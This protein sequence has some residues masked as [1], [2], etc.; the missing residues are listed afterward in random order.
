MLGSLVGAPDEDQRAFFDELCA[1]H[2]VALQAAARHV[3]RDATIASDLVQDTL[4]RAWRNLASLQDEGHA[5]AWLVRIMRNAW[6]D[7]IRRRKVEVPLEQVEEP[8]AT[9]VDEPMDWEALTIDDVRMAIERLEEPF[10]TVAI[11]H[12][13]DGCSYQ[14]IAKRLAIPYN[15]AATRLHRARRMLRTTL[16]YKLRETR[17]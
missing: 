8:P 15:T 9:V 7:Q 16:Q 1:K 4:E 17:S 5:R 3:C 6:L 13:L 12:D 2:L 11:L 14:E 10:R